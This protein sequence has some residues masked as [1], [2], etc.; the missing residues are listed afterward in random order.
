MGEN[1][2]FLRVLNRAVLQQELA[3]ACMT[4]DPKQRPT[5]DR[6]V[7]VLEELVLAAEA[8]EFMPQ[9]NIDDYEQV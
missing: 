2:F 9:D 7:M 1:V 4:T 8:G 6:V 3:E 5:F